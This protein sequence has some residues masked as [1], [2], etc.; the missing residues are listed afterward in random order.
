MET[1]RELKVP[2]DN[3]NLIKCFYTNPVFRVRMN[4]ID[5]GWNQEKAGIRQ[6]C[7]LS[8]YLF[9]LSMSFFFPLSDVTPELNTP[10]QCQSFEGIYFSEIPFA[11]GTLIF[12]ANTECINVLLRAIERHSVYFRFELGYRSH[13]GI[14]GEPIFYL[15]LVWARRKIRFK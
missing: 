3:I 7:P 4:G 11:D 6:G 2:D 10:K 12:G 13:S 14:I 9:R 15:K 1:L 5:A 8:P